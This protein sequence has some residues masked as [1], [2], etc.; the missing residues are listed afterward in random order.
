M[1]TRLLVGGAFVDGEGEPEAILNP[2]TG[3]TIAAVPEASRSQVD[4]AVA[5]AER[6]FPRW[7]R[8][9]PAERSAALLKVADRLEAQAEAF[10]TL[11]SLNTGKPPAKALGDELP[12]IVDCF[13]FFAGAARC[14]SGGAAAASTWPG[15][16]R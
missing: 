4:G 16:P 8:T 9:T 15:S 13:R 12:A 11:E 14:Q 6:A 3:E 1:Q 2:A 5:A 10:A 7:A